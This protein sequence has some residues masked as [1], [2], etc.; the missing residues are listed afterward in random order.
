MQKILIEIKHQN[1]TFSYCD[2][3]STEGNFTS[4]TEDGINQI[5]T[6]LEYI[7]KKMDL[8]TLYITRSI[9]ENEIIYLNI[10]DYNLTDIAFKLTSEKNFES[11]I[12][13]EENTLPK[14]I[15]TLI[16]ENK[17]KTKSIECYSITKEMFESLTG[18]N[19]KIGLQKVDFLINKLMEKNEFKTYSDI[20]DA[21]EIEFNFKPDI[22]DLEDFENFLNI[23]KNLESINIKEYHEGL[24]KQLMSI[25]IKT[26]RCG[27]TI[28][29]YENNEDIIKYLPH[30]KKLRKQCKKCCD[31][32][33]I[34]SKQYK[35]KI[36]KKQIKNIL[37]FIVIFLLIIMTAY[38]IYKL[39]NKN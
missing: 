26:K 33:F 20:E 12:F 31:I 23:N 3:N 2:Y 1:L 9:N 38:F 36:L 34:Y 35:F 37:I 11:I 39:I 6:T 29:I 7:E 16:F 25:L 30:L 32:K 28:N 22:Y 19:I 13:T 24:E 18:N 15:Y 27:V 17:N 14:D 4:I 21:Y 5:T 8:F 10:K